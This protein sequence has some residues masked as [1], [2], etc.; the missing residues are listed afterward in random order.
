MLWVVEKDGADA[1]RTG[2]QIPGCDQRLDPE[3]PAR[4]TTG[5]DDPQFSRAARAP[6]VCENE[7]FVY[8]VCVIPRM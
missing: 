7:H 1:R 2:P 3:A 5:G 8:F 6:F 4:A